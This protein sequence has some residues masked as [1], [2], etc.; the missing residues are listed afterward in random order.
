[1]EKHSEKGLK[2]MELM[3][4]VPTEWGFAPIKWEKK[5]RL[6]STDIPCPHCGGFDNGNGYTAWRGLGI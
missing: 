4:T 6:V 3:G 5:E 1:M 2:T